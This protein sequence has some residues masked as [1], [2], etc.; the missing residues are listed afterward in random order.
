MSFHGRSRNRL[1]GNRNRAGSDEFLITRVDNEIQPFKR[2]CPQQQEISLFCENHFI[3]R[4]VFPNSYDREADTPGDP[5][6]VG[7]YE[8]EIFFLAINSDTFQ[9]RLGKPRIFTSR[10]DQ[11][12]GKSELPLPI[13]MVLNDT[14]C[15][16]R[17][18]NQASLTRPA[19]T[20]SWRTFA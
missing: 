12:P 10:I 5:L 3:R 17:S 14:R 2:A 9:R 4:E 13:Q 16:E 8:R 15:I 1:S 19:K 7:H 6:T 18:H 20:V 11:D